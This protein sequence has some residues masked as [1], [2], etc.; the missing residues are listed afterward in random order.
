MKV[1]TRKFLSVGAILLVATLAV[2]G[3]TSRE[4]TIVKDVSFDNH[5]DSLEA[6]ITATGESKY[7]YFELKQPRRL[8]LDFIGIQNTIKFREK[9]IDAAGVER[10]RTSLFSDKNR[11]AT[12]IVFDLSKNVSYRVIDD[13]GGIVRVVF[14]DAPPAPQNQI[15]GPVASA[16]P[17]K[18]AALASSAAAAPAPVSP[19]ESLSASVVNLGP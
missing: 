3:A 13:G 10:V 11:T 1:D 12:R 16:L 6:K 8:V 2:N 7:T 15:A 14:G 17:A 5:G 18:P 9:K 19:T 4:A